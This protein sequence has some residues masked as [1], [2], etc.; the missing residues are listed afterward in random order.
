MLASVPVDLT[1]TDNANA[2]CDLIDRGD[3]D[4]V[5]LD[6]VSPECALV[7]NFARAIPNRPFL[8]VLAG[9][10]RAVAGGAD[11][12]AFKPNTAQEASQLIDR[13]V[14][15]RLPNRVL[16]IDDS[17]TTRSIVRKILEASRF[18]VVVEEADKGES[19]LEQVR[20]GGIDIA[21]LDYNMPELDGVAAVG[22][23]KRAFPKLAVVV[24]TATKDKGMAERAFESGATGILHKPFYP[25]DV[26]KFLYGQFGLTPLKT[27]GA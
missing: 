8:I 13:W 17:K 4:L 22:A 27:T 23:L 9:A 24:M 11:A 2:A 1:D 12:M 7:I 21:F 3:V 18:Q 25:A 6:A 14:R 26:D 10:G 16:V 5:L 19:A 20:N 15:V